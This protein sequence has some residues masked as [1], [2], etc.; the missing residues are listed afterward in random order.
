MLFPPGEKT[1]WLEISFWVLH[2]WR[3]G[4]HKHRWP[5]SEGSPHLSYIAGREVPPR[6]GQCWWPSDHRPFSLSKILTSILPHGL[7]P[8][9]FGEVKICSYPGIFSLTFLYLP[10]EISLTREAFM[11]CSRG[12]TF[13]HIFHCF[14]LFVWAHMCAWVCYLQSNFF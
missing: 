7:L 12:G 14:A 13:V 2:L 11:Q 9:T 10:Q 1:E 4:T 5:T 6:V 8:L 3:P